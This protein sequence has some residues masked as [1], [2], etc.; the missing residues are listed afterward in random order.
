MLSNVHRQINK[1]TDRQT[2]T[3]KNITS[4]AKEVIKG[5]VRKQQNSAKRASYTTKS[6][7]KKKWLACDHL[8]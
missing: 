1:Q 7:C 6:R 8:M 4:F 5:F 3:T 2:S